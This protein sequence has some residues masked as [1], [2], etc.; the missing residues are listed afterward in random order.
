MGDPGRRTLASMRTLLAPRFWGAH[1]LLLL[2]VAAATLLGLWQWH[3]WQANRAAAKVDV[4]AKPAVPLSRV[5]GGDD[6]FNGRYVGRQVTLRGTWLSEDTVFVSDK[7]SGQDRGYWVVTPVLVGRSAMPVVR[8]WSPRP[9]AASPS[10]SVSLTGWLQ[11]SEDGG[12]PASN[13]RDRVLSTMQIANLVE[14]VDH[15]LYSA[16]VI[17]RRAD[18]AGPAGLRPVGSH[19]TPDVSGATS[20]RNLLYAF[21]WWIFGGFAIYLWQRWCRDQL[22]DQRAEDRV[23]DPSGH[24]QTDERRPVPSAQ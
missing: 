14:Y 24:E 19:V 17:Q 15:D 10:G 7:R 20:L 6:P 18:P 4:A 22:A 2:A 3:V 23:E 13:P 9:Q 12:A 1:L 11:P 21:Q 16:F 5:M 8:G